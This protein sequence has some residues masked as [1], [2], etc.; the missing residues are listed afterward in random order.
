MELD[1]FGWDDG[2]AAAN[3]H[4]HHG[5]SFEAATFIF[6]NIKA[7]EEIDDRMWYSEERRIIIGM[8]ESELLFFV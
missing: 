6:D 5:V 1:G 4:S 8:G 2:K 3:V 7:L